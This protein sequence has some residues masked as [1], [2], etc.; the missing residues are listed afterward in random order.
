MNKK[1]YSSR[2]IDTNEA[3]KSARAPCYTQPEDRRCNGHLRFQI[4]ISNKPLERIDVISKI[5]IW[6]VTSRKCAL[7]STKTYQSN[8]D[9]RIQIETCLVIIIMGPKNMVALRTSR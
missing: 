9:F 3:I 7:C 1:Q 6:N 4:S 8:Q 2:I 5:R